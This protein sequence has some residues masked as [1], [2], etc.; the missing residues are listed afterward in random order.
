MSLDHSTYLQ[1]V[2]RN[3][4]KQNKTKQNKT[5]QNKTKRPLFYLWIHSKTHSSTFFNIINTFLFCQ[6][7]CIKKRQN[8]WTK[9]D[10][11]FVGPH[12]TQGRLMDD[13]NFSISTKEID[14]ATISIK[15]KSKNGYKPWIF[16]N[17]VFKTTGLRHK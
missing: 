3:E 9:R 15:K 4:T 5:K 17:K 7:V 2:L 14:W 13:F 8:G 1:D 6:D 16:I 11:I 12:M 10:K